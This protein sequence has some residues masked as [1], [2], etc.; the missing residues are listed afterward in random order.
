M[1]GAIPQ[2]LLT[3]ILEKIDN[4]KNTNTES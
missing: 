3:D 2:S 1:V 4:H